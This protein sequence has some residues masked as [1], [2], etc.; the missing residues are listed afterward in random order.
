MAMFINH[1]HFIDDVSNRPGPGLDRRPVLQ[2]DLDAWVIRLD[3]Q[4]EGERGAVTWVPM[5]T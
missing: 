5:S 4:P 2:V 1:I 3:H